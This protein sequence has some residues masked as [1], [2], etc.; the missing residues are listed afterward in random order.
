ML[1]M[2]KTVEAAPAAFEVTREVPVY[3]NRSGALVE[4]GR[5]LPGETFKIE[6]DFGANWWKIR[7]A[8]YYGYVAK[9]YT[10]PVNNVSYKNDAAA[11]ATVKDQLV[12]T[13]TTDVHD[14]KTQAPHLVPFAKILAGQKYPIYSVM[15]AWY[16]IELNG[17]LGFIHNS[18]VQVEKGTTTP[19]KPTTPTGTGKLSLVE[20]TSYA[21]ATDL[22][23]G[24]KPMEMVNFYKGT[25]LQI[26]DAPDQYTDKYV[27][28]RWGKTYLYMNKK[29]VKEINKSNE[30]FKDDTR[31]SKQFIIP[32]GP[33]TN[34]I[35][36]SRN[37]KLNA[38]AKLDTNRRYPVLRTEGQWYIVSFGGREGYIHNTKVNK[39]RGVPVLMYHHVLPNKD[40]GYFRNKSTTVSAEQFSSEMNYLKTA[41]FETVTLEDFRRYLRQEI[42]LPAYAVVI[43][44][45]DGLLSTKH[46]AYPVLKQHGFKAAQF[47][48]TQRNNDA[49]LQQK[50]SPNLLQALNWQDTRDMSDIFTFEGHT[51]NLHNLING[52]TSNVLTV[53]NAQ[54]LEDLRK[55]INSLPQGSRAFAYPFGQF[56]NTTVQLVRQ[57]G[58]DLAFTTREGYNS[59]FENPYMIKRVYSTQAVNL[60]QYKRMVSPF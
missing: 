28:I 31:V 50:F 22:R 26:V 13:G 3:D 30:N 11:L 51:N 25:Q 40:L 2:G 6:S 37:G 5:L 10:K 1:G 29:H 19:T 7:W 9:S 52:K 60:A 43:T 27:K 35:Y 21:P 12:F 59:P 55:N 18:K 49:S 38:F 33:T 45:D 44:F 53:S 32:K 56:N 16:G 42:T 48:I 34:T 36:A 14:N 54:L 58:F 39:D 41:N 4:V 57:A 46:Y 17:R 20:T 8:N 15:G 24:N 23:R 47:L